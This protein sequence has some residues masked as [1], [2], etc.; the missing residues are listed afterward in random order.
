MVLDSAPNQ[1]EKMKGIVNLEDICFD[2]M[3]MQS[4]G[5]TSANGSDVEYFGFKQNTNMQVGGSSS[6]VSEG[7]VHGGSLMALLASGS[8]RTSN[9]SKG[10]VTASEPGNSFLVSKNWM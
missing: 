5:M 1:S 7:R 4:N 10:T 3:K 2:A 9:S 8:G 6:S